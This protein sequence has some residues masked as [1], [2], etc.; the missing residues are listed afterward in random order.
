MSTI[1]DLLKHGN[2]AVVNMAKNRYVGKYIS[3][4][5]SIKILED[6]RKQVNVPIEAMSIPV[7]EKEEYD[8]ATEEIVRKIDETIKF[9]KEN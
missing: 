7:S 1:I 6:F 2:I 8:K 9:I 4:E 3:R 5:D